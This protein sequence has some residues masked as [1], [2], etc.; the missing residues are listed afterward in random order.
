MAHGNCKKAVPLLVLGQ[1]WRRKLFGDGPIIGLRFEPLRGC[2]TWTRMEE[3]VMR[4]P[5]IG[6]G[7]VCGGFNVFC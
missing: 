4:P 7:E 5:I 6:L 3:K 2:G 1:E